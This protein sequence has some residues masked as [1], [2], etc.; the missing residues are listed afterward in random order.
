MSKSPA[1]L[2]RAG[3]A[4]MAALTMLQLAPAQA[5]TQSQNKAAAA[6][7]D[8]RVVA[9]VK[10]SKILFRDVRIAH[11]NLP[12]QYRGLALDKVYRPL[13]QQLVERRLVL[14]AAEA[15]K[16][17]D[18]P[19][20]I[21]RVAQARE[22]I[23]EQTFLSNRINAV[24]TEAN[25]R[26]R[27]EAEKPQIK[28]PEEVRA[29]HILVETQAEADAIVAELNK[30][31]DFAEIAKKKSKGPSGAKGG[32]LGYFTK[33]KMV[34]E[35][36][37]A[38]FALKIDEISAPVK[39]GFGWH[40]IKLVDRRKSQGPSYAQRA[41]ELRQAMAQEVAE[42]LLGTLAKDADIKYFELDGSPGEAP[43]I[44]TQTK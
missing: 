31:G 4:T 37:N 16:L 33:D 19:A 1:A 5:Q 15:E 9:V 39:T 27:Y 12:Q 18:D 21:K 24:A 7:A 23:L 28:G 11:Q 2:L 41:P 10:G 42:E 36:A 38:A 22:R 13:V 17:G 3:L 26:A 35:F 43:V 40:V 34:P 8:D 14:L 32:D 20:I 25:M 44:G 29:S 6:N 30:G